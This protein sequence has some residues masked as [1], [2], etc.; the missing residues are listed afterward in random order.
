MFDSS[1]IDKQNLHLSIDAVKVI[2]D[3]R[4][5]FKLHVLVR[6]LLL[7]IGQEEVFHLPLKF[8]LWLW[9][10]VHIVLDL[11][12]RDCAIRGLLVLTLARN[13]ELTTGLVWISGRLS[14]LLVQAS[15]HF[16]FILI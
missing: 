9:I 2:H 3:W 5:S 13:H 15:K 7:I 16:Y 4:L 10:V 11:L 8:R 1:N 12:G 6:S 14:H